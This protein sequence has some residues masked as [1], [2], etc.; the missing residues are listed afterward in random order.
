MNQYT[1]KRSIRSGHQ[2]KGLGTVRSTQEIEHL[3]SFASAD[4]VD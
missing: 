1:M 4:F 3:Y 2:Q